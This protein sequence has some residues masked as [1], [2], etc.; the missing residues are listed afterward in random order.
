[1][2]NRA[3]EIHDSVLDTIFILEGYAVL[4]FSSAYIHQ[5]VGTPLVDAGSGWVQKAR[6]RIGDAVIEGSFPEMP[7]DLQDGYI[8]LG[9]TVLENQIP[10]LLKY[11]GAVELRIESWGE[12]VLITGGSAE[13]ELL[14]KA[15]YVEE[16]Q[17]G[18]DV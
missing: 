13:L 14:G 12:V 17:P 7:S 15:E 4:Y 10:I 1:V 6:L 11:V 8:K 16:F 3:I 9:G 2:Q 18:R 5:S